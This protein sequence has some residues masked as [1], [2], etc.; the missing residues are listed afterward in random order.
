MITVSEMRKLEDNCGIDK[1]QLMENAGK[2]MAQV[3]DG[4]PGKNVLVLCYH[5][6]NGGDGFVLA[7]YLK[8]KYVDIWFI[9]EEEKLTDIAK[10]NYDK[11]KHKVIKEPI[12]A[13]YD[14]IVDCILGIGFKGE[15]KGKIKEVVEK[16][17]KS[18]AFKVS[19][20]VPTA[21]KLKAD[22]ILTFHDIKRGL[23]KEKTKV[24]DIGINR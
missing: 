3:I 23:D 12:I 16:I 11:I 19:C 21:Y 8:D 10:I 22:L 15:L 7:R 17:N 2:G 4:L 13:G 18:S 6:N 14:I 5:G 20:D 24:I 1:L 9:G